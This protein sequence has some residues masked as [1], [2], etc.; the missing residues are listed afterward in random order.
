MNC[1]LLDVGG[2]L[3]DES[4]QV[5][6]V[7]HSGHVL[8]QLLSCHLLAPLHEHNNVVH[9]LGVPSEEL[10]GLE[11]TAYLLLGVLLVL[12][13]HLLIKL[14]GRLHSGGHTVQV[15]LR[16]VRLHWWAWLVHARLLH[17]WLLHTWLMHARL[18]HARLVHAWLL[19]ARLVH[20]RLLHA[21]LAGL[22]VNDNLGALL[23]V[24][25]LVNDDLSVSLVL[26]G[27]IHLFVHLVGHH[28]PLVLSLRR[29]HI[30]VLLGVIGLLGRDISLLVHN[31]RGYILGHGGRL[32]AV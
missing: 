10:V 11:V 1:H 2:G 8:D 25:L 16:H 4:V 28:S 26:V 5:L 31:G 6:L 29:G 7:G 9:V 13:V 14:V 21:W 23:V 30:G 32:V 3:L 18:L 20:T 15:L 17:A 19:H 24:V 12:H 22:L 27:L